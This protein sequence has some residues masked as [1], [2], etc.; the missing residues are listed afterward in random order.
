MYRS[1]NNGFGVGG[2]VIAVIVIIF[3]FARGCSQ[4]GMTRSWGGEMDLYMEPNQKLQLV[5]WK[6]DN[7]WILAKDMTEDD[8]AEDYSYYEKDPMGMF[9]GAIHIHEVKLT[10]EELAEREYQTKLSNDYY[11]SS[12]FDENGDTVFIQYNESTNTYTELVPYCYD[13]DGNLVAK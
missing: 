1:S 10:E 7:L 3:S 6:D 12:N 8:I 2:L 9:E 11:M 4:Q 5:T 13:E